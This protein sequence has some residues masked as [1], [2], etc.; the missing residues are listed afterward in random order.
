MTIRLKT[1]LTI[2][3]PLLACSTL[4]SQSAEAPSGMR[5]VRCQE[6]ANC[7]HKFISGAMLQIL[8]ENGIVVLTMIVDTGRYFRV[9]VAV[10]NNTS[11]PVDVL[12]SSFTLRLLQPKQ[13]ELRY[14]PPEK[15]MKSISNRAALDNFFTALGAAGATQQIASQTNTTGNVSVY[16]NGGSANGT[17]NQR[18][19]ST[20]TVPDEQARQNAAEHIS[21]NNVAAANAA[22]EVNSFS[23]RATTIDPGKLATGSVYFERARKV[24]RTVTRIPINDVVYE[25]SFGW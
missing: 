9:D 5:L 13:K 6:P 8:N 14:Q 1:P 18:S 19:T 12:P 17:Y 7:S 10:V 4:W 23:L 20:T 22:Q 3:L 15:V 24:E 2:F 11:Q 16:S 25:F 21:A